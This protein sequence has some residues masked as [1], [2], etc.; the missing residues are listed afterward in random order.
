[1]K[2]TLYVCMVG[3]LITTSNPSFPGTNALTIE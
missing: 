3:S 2:V 1:M